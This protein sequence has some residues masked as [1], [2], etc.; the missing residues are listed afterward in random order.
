[1]SNLT[2][3]NSLP[4]LQSID[5]PPTTKNHRKEI[6]KVI[7][8]QLYISAVFPPILIFEWMPLEQYLHGDANVNMVDQKVNGAQYC[9]IVDLRRHFILI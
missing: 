1:M 7:Y 5:A 8:A 9:R 6:Q 3:F 2:S 4:H